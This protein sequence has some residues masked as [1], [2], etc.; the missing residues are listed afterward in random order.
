MRPRAAAAVGVVCIAALAALLTGC[1]GNAAT[2]RSGAVVAKV[3][4]EEI[5]LRQLEA[6]ADANGTDTA[7]LLESLI[8]EE[9]LMQRALATHLDRDPAVVLEIERAR[10]QILAR[11]YERSVLPQVEISAA[12]KR[13]YY[14]AN[15]ALFARRRV[16]RTLTFSIARAQLTRALRN[17]LDHARSAIGVRQLLDQHSVA[18][19]AVE[20]TRPAEQIPMNLLPQLAQAAPGDVLIASP[21]RDAHALLICVVDVR[22]SPVD[23]EHASVQIRQYL[24]D[25]RN[26]E[27]LAQYLRRAR[28]V[29]SVSYGG[30]GESPKLQAAAFE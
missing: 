26:R 10:R 5:T 13:E 1:N 12:A 20:T 2:K 25:A 24:T 6:A 29:G 28:S 23:F 3:N 22:D 4:D 9:L 14:R 30:S 15:P 19:E 27:V 7:A 16:Y 18:F 17:A 8:D 21:P 11:A